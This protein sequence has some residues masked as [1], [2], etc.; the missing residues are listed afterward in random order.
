MTHLS[1]LKGLWIVR[2]NIIE[3][4]FPE[5]WHISWFIHGNVTRW[6]GDT[7]GHHDVVWVCTKQP[8]G[9]HWPLTQPGNSGHLPRLVW[10][11]PLASPPAVI[12]RL[13]GKHDVS[14]HG[15]GNRGSPRKLQGWTGSTAPTK[16]KK[17]LPAF[18]Q[19]NLLGRG[20]KGQ[21][22][23]QIYFSKHISRVGSSHGL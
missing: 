14:R 2:V 20:K 17:N 7:G 18:V 3:G 15:N 10:E 1:I 19:W 9:H 5:T 23:S 21:V 16:T 8:K 6:Q 13:P 4:F 11:W 12:G 22:H